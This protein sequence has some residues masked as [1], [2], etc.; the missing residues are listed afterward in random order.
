MVLVLMGVSGTGKTTIGKLLATKLGW[1]FKNA[2]DFLYAEW[3]NKAAG[4]VGYGSAG[5]LQPLQEKR[6]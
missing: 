4:F 3:N 6:A 1:A 2:I 5:A